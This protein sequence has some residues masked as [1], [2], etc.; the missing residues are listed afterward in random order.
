MNENSYLN[1]ADIR[2][3]CEEAIVNLEEDNRALGIMQ[4]NIMAFIAEPTLVSQAFDALKQQMFD[5]LFVLQAMKSANEADIADYRLL[6][7]MAVGQELNG[8]TILEQKD[9]ALSLRKA[10][11]ENAEK[12]RKRLSLIHI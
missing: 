1:P 4:K 8:S 3:Q 2:T 9:V 5:Y 7:L 6:K 11:E 10:S 12:Y